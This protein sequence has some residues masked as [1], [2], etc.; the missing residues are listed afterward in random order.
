MTYSTHQQ[1][2]WQYATTPPAPPW[3]APQGA[4]WG[5]PPQLAFAVPYGGPREMRRPGTLL[6]ATIMAYVGSGPLV[7]F[8]VVF[9]VGSLSESFVAGFGDAG[10]LGSASLADQRLLMLGMG[11]GTLVLGLTVAALALF[12]QL[13]RRWAHTALTVVGALYTLV[14]LVSVVNGSPQ[15]IVGATY[16]GVAIMLLWIGGAPAWYRSRRSHG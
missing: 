8:G 4:P 7:L 12:A 9:L 13:G 5:Q 2:P 3:Q 15:T 14:S 10:G 1:G 16:V 11:S 6:A